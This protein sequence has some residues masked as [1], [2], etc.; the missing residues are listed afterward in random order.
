MSAKPPPPHVSPPSMYYSKL[1]LR[2]LQFVIS[3]AIV[4]LVAS[5]A[6]TGLYAFFNLIIIIPQAGV[7]IIWAVSEI[8]CIWARGGHRGIHPGACVAVDLLLWLALVGGTAGLTLLGLLTTV[9]DAVVDSYQSGSYYSDYDDDYYYGETYDILDDIQV[10]GQALV[11]L[12]AVLTILHFVTFVIACVETS[13]RNS[14]PQQVVYLGP[15]QHNSPMHPG[16]GGQASPYTS[17][18][19]TNWDHGQ[20]APVYSPQPQ[21]QGQVYYQGGQ[22]VKA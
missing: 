11:G 17:L 7:S 13:I 4:G 20:P 9:A 5:L 12:G 18:S 15:N 8:I 2:V 22:R 16:M 10:K 21:E 1:A 3:I 6:S 19:A 14:R